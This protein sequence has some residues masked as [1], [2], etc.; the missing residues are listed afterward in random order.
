MVPRKNHT[1]DPAEQT[2]APAR[3]TLDPIVAPA[4]PPVTV[5]PNETPHPNDGRTPL[6]KIERSPGIPPPLKTK[7][8]QSLPVPPE[9]I[10]RTPVTTSSRNQIPLTSLGLP[11]IPKR[12]DRKSRGG[13]IPTLKKNAPPTP[14]IDRVTPTG[15]TPG[16]QICHDPVRVVPDDLQPEAKAKDPAIGNVT[17]GLGLIGTLPSS[18]VSTRS[19]GG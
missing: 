3:H 16:M 19:R 13:P 10:P 15:E 1:L 6:V 4:R 2:G 7:G 14:P 12:E 18:A 8:P 9:G 5:P 11:I 17:T